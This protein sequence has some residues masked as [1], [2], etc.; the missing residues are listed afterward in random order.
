MDSARA[1]DTKLIILVRTRPVQRSLGPSCLGALAAAGP[2]TPK[3]CSCGVMDDVGTGVN[4]W[5]S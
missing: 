3:H 4:Q 1:S 5:D 2:A